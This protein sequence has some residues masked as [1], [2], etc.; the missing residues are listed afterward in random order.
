M[1]AR[2]L[3]VDTSGWFSILVAKDPHH[4]ETASVYADVLRS[5]GTLVTTSLILGELYTLLSVRLKNAA[6]FW[7]FKELLTASKRV[8]IAHVQPEHVE[9]A[10]DLLSRRADQSY[11]FVH[12]TSFVF[13]RSEDIQTALALDKH[14]VQEGFVVLPSFASMVHERP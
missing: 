2:R 8:H 13:I 12:A 6:A 14:F 10:F 5:G 9:R 3:F 11:S 7:S 1:T 4:A